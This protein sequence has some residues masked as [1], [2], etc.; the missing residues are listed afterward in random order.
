MADNVGT[1]WVANFFADDFWAPGFW[2]DLL[3]T[4]VQDDCPIVVKPDIEVIMVEA[5]C[6][7]KVTS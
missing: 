6:C 3:Q 2:S 4:V 5:E 7:D 1:V